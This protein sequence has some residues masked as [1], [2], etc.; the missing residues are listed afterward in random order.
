MDSGEVVGRSFRVCF[1]LFG[2][3]RY[4]WKGLGVEEWLSSDAMNRYKIRLFLN[5]SFLI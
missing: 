3:L 5:A 4:R 1:A 2:F